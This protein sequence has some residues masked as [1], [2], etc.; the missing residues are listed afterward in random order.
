MVELISS[1][2]LL[3]NC[4]CL[5]SSRE[6]KELEQQ[7]CCHILLSALNL[8]GG[9]TMHRGRQTSEVQFLD[10]SVH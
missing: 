1:R 5:V 4:F 6:L 3:N 8:V 9:I 2:L 10:V 7:R